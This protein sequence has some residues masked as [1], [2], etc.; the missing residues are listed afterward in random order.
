MGLHIYEA[1]VASHSCA[2]RLYIGL[3]PK[4]KWN[5]VINNQETVLRKYYRAGAEIELRS[6]NDGDEIICVAANRVD[7]LGV[8]RGLLRPAV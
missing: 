4:R 3:L 2:F 5:T 1:F 7:I 8:F 6:S